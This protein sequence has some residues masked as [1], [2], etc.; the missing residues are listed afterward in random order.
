LAL[1]ATATVSPM[2]FLGAP[3]GHDFQFHL[4]SWID[5]AAQWH[6][7]ILY[8]RWAEWANWGYGEPRFIFYP[9][10]SWML[11]ATLGTIL[12]WTAAPVAYI[13]LTLVASGMSMWKLARE[14]LSSTESAVSAVFFAL[15]PY[16]LLVA[17]Y[18][19][20]FAELLAAALFPL[21]ILGAWRVIQEGWPRV[22]FLALV[23]AGI[24]LCDAPAAVIATYSL[25]LL[26]AIG[27]ALRRS[28][29]SA[30]CGATALAAGFG[31]AAFYIIPA[32]TERKW[33]QIAE[34]ISENLQPQRNFV[35]T[36]GGDPEFVLFNWKV[37]TLALGVIL[38]VGILG[39]FAARRR[40]EFPQLWWILVALSAVSAL[41]MFSPSE[42]VWRILP[43]LRFV[44]F[45][46]RFLGVLAVPF[47][48]FA[49]SALGRPLLRPHAKQW[50]LWLVL[51]SVLAGTATALG[52]DTW[53][54]SDDPS[55]IASWVHD[56]KGYE[57]TDEYAPLGCDRYDL[58]GINPDSEDSPENPIPMFAELKPNSGAI[59]K[60]TSV[61][62]QITKSTAEERLF[63][64][65]NRT[66]VKLAVRMIDYPA[67]AASIDGEAL[68]ID[69]AK[70]THEMILTLPGGAHRIELCFRRTR[71]R[72]LGDIISL[73][74]AIGLC[75]WAGARGTAPGRVA[76]SS[77]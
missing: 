2:F 63:S 13:W 60:E 21:L 62:V 77:G 74:S 58:P 45:P 44:Q 27:V 10:A 5:V 19:S 50:V 69:A 23:F 67:W 56:G 40:R 26:L 46:W 18:R 12:G 66:P 42:F 35:F 61:S 11:G 36:R 20:D 30:L 16:N 53:W 54:D 31:L 73:M 8:P 43:E 4:A 28:L 9:P 72:L 75:L 34:A 3:S 32:A 6:E 65:Q 55:T 49:A 38:L 76:P 1:A 7:G 33:V 71:D 29:R 41:T 24:W 70:A 15:N 17:Y 52:I 47:A 68:R 14:W 57:G 22:P 25:V 59:L 64:E 37:S 39:I 51:I 48:F